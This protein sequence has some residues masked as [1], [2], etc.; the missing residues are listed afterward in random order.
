MIS[1]A[2]AIDNGLSVHFEEDGSYIERN[3]EQS[4]LHR[5]GNLFFSKFKLLRDEEEPALIAPIEHPDQHFDAM[6]DDFD[7]D[8]HEVEDNEFYNPEDHNQ[9]II[10]DVVPQ[11]I[12]AVL[13]QPVRHS[14]A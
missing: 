14:Q 7:Q 11:P 5:R 9:D 3:H 6:F 10:P 4:P 12:L 8:A 13:N 1:V 2:R